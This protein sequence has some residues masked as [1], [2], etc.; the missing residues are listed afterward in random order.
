MS[1]LL[2]C[3]SISKRF[4]PTTVLSDVN[5]TVQAGE[6]LCLVGENGAGK[7]TLMNI[8]TGNLQATSGSMSLRGQT[9]NPSNS[10]DAIAHSISIIHQ[11]LNLFT[12]L[13]IAENLFIDNLPTRGVL[14]I[15]KRSLIRSQAHEVLS[16]VGLRRSPDELLGSLSIGERQLVEFAKALLAKAQLVVLDEP[17][18]S[19]TQP[20]IDRLTAQVASLKAEGVAIIYISHNL[21]EVF[22]IA[23]RI[24][25]LRDGR[26]VA[27]DAAS[28]F[29]AKRLI[30]MMVGRDVGQLFPVR[31]SR[32]GSAPSLE[33][34]DITQPGVVRSITLTVEAGEIVGLAGLM[35]SG[36]SEL[37]RIVFGLDLFA[38][39]TIHLCATRFAPSPRESIRKGL[40][41]LTENRR[42]D[43]VALDAT[44]GDSISVVTLAKHCIRPFGWL[45]GSAQ[46][47][48]A[49]RMCA[50]V[51]LDPSARLAQPVG[52]L[53][54]G[55]QQKVIL[56]K[57]LMAQPR[58]L[59]LDEPTRGIDIGAKADVYELIAR[60]AENGT[61]I[62]LISSELEELTGLCDRIAVMREGEIVSTFARADFDR[63]KI[64]AAAFGLSRSTSE[65][66]S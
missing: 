58:V 56:G 46:R 52:Q 8:L 64:M 62:L 2:E 45:K 13:S 20:E 29:D 24:A 25:V 32:A 40:A 50:Q 44:V 57:W 26:L 3:R 6:V 7:S 60:L 22:R 12:N 55:N 15:I 39:G 66:T 65:S 34:R 18:S 47:Q 41:F 54:G 16:K 19:L 43:G 10:R 63:E 53:S 5:L 23:D 4:G 48:A 11:E 21:N 14:P 9:Y 51:R 38:A 31:P 17:T 37:A 49:D 35:G 36:R 1:P 28:N 30:S 42:Q 33:L 27:I 61:A 59:I